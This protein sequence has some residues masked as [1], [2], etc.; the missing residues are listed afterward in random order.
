MLKAWGTRSVNKLEKQSISSLYKAY[1]EYNP[2]TYVFEN[3]VGVKEIYTCIK[4]HVCL[5]IIHAF[6][7]ALMKYRKRYLFVCYV[8]L[9]LLNSIFH[10]PV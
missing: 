2:F 10:N 6:C 5:L 4:Q 3:K 1:I 7:G 9:F 8:I